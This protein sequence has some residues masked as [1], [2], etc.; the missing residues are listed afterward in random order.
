MCS[1]SSLPEHLRQILALLPFV[2]LVFRQCHLL[3]AI[4]ASGQLVISR[5][6]GID[7]G[8]L[9][10]AV[11]VRPTPAARMEQTMT[12]TLGSFW[13]ASTAA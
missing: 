1:F 4:I 13:K 6:V 10:A 11:S 8:Q 9:A 3:L 2:L 7:D 12:F 5:P